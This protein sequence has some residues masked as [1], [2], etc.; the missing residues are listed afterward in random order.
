MILEQQVHALELRM[1]KLEK[2]SHVPVT[3]IEDGGMV[4]GNMGILVFTGLMCWMLT[5]GWP[6]FFPIFF[7]YSK[8]K[9]DSNIEE[10]K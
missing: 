4:I 5:S 10:P 1:R 3:F 6:L 8:S 7:H 2:L 9:T